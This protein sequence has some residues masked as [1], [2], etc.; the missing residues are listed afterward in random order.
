[1]LFAFLQMLQ[2]LALM[3]AVVLMA[4]VFKKLNVSEKKAKILKPVIVIFVLL[5]FFVP[6]DEIVSFST[7]EKAFSGTVLG[8]ALAS[9]EGETTCG[10]FYRDPRGTYSTVFFHQNGERY[11]KCA[12]EARETVFSAEE[13]GIYVDIYRIAETDDAYIIVR[14]FVEKLDIHDNLSTDFEVL[15]ASTSE[16]KL[17]LSMQ[18]IA[19]DDTYELYIGETRVTP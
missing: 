12:S 15:S 7:P 16:G 13:N 11:K 19:Y 4:L 1:M 3:L 8:D 18:S 10:T 14:G 6:F 5:F 2:W 9:A 17:L